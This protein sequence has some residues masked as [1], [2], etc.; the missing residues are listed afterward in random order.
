MQGKNGY[1]IPSLGV[2]PSFHC[3]CHDFGGHS[4][5]MSENRLIWRLSDLKETG[6][7]VSHSFLRDID[8]SCPSQHI[9]SAQN[10]SIHNS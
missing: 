6:F 10:H 3:G 2:H 8:S 7:Q 9:Q 5:S 4:N 1:R